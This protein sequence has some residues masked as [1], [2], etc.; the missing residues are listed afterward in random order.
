MSTELAEQLVTEI[1]KFRSPSAAVL[2]KKVYR[3]LERAQVDVQ[4]LEHD[5]WKNYRSEAEK[6]LARSKALRDSLE[7]KIES[8]KLPPEKIAEARKRLINAPK[9]IAA[10]EKVLAEVI[11]HRPI[12]PTA[13][14]P[15]RKRQSPIAPIAIEKAKDQPK[16]H[17]FEWVIGNMSHFLSGDEITAASRLRECFINAQPKSRVASYDGIPAPSRF[18]SSVPVNDRMLDASYEFN[19]LWHALPLSLKIVAQNF[20][21]EQAPIGCEKP[22][23][24]VEFGQKYVTCK[25][26]KMAAGAADAAIKSTC[27]MLAATLKEYYA[28]KREQKKSQ[29][30]GSNVVPMRR[31]I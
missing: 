2:K 5:A 12:W 10:H 19:A 14:T 20:I 26:R 18:G 9:N 28:W 13:P 3:T 21:L 23:S 15:E 4:Q 1:V 30:R 29:Q 22:M 11:A 31:K 24:R 16:A 6:R 25:C 8:G 27:T 7:R 17:K